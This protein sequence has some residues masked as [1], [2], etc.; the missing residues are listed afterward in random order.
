MPRPSLQNVP[1]F[2]LWA[3]PA[4]LPWLR[5]RRPACVSRDLPGDSARPGMGCGKPPSP[6]WLN[7][8]GG[9]WLMGRSKTNKGLSRNQPRP[10]PSRIMP[11]DPSRGWAAQL[12]ARF[13]QS[14]SRILQPAGRDLQ[15]PR[16]LA[17]RPGCLAQ[18]RG[19]T[20]PEP[21]RPSQSRGRPLRRRGRITQPPGRLF[22]RPGRSLQSP[23]RTLQ[24]PG[25]TPQSPGRTPQSPGRMIQSPGRTMQLCVSQGLTTTTTQ[26]DQAEGQC[27]G[28]RLVEEHFDLKPDTRNPNAE[29]PLACRKA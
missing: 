2:L 19:R 23:G 12:P 1:W 21:G 8:R 9:S 7:S 20:L 16:R 28:R 4:P 6:V 5:L 25:R 10:G 13:P 3:P 11:P 15:S 27:W 17:Q 26:R 22:Q 29:Q 18:G 24:S 14:V